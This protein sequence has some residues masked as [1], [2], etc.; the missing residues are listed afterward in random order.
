MVKIGAI[1]KNTTEEG[2]VY[3]KGKI[4]LPAPVMIGEGLDILLF[5]SKSTHE[6]APYFDVLIAKPR[7]KAER[8]SRAENDFD[9]PGPPD[10]E[11]PF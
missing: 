8:P 9:D 1:W 7:P 4:D 11:I 10:D 2:K 5:K 6:K 3:F